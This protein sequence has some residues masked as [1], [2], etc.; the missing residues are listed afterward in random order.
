MEYCRSSWIKVSAKSRLLSRSELSSEQIEV[1]DWESTS[2]GLLLFLTKFSKAESD[3][4]L[5]LML[6]ESLK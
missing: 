4:F 3:Y 6:L 2:D 1:S 5:E